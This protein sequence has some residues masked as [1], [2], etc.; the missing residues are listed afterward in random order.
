MRSLERNASKSSRSL[1][2]IRD[3]VDFDNAASGPSASASRASMSRSDRPRTHP[4]MTSA[5]SGSVRTT[6]LPNS[7]DANASAVL[8][9]FGR[10]RLTGPAVVLTVTSP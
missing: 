8:R 7:A 4:E 10:F 6:P 2:Q 3:A 1:A 9:S 5:S